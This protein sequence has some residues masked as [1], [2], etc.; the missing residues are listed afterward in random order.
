MK[1]WSQLLTIIISALL[2]LTTFTFAE[3]GL[4]PITG[5][6]LND[7]INF[8]LNGVSTVPVGDDGTPVLPISYKGTTYIPLRALGYL[9]GL[10][11]DY[12]G[13]TKT[14]L[15]TSTTTKV[16][17]TAVPTAK[18]NKLIAIAGALINEQLKF[19]LDS[20]AATPK[21]DDGVP[22]LPISYNG[23]TYLPVRAV[24][25]LLGLSITYKSTSR[26]VQIVNSKKYTD[27]Q[28]NQV[29]II[30][31]VKAFADKAVTLIVGNPAPADSKFKNPAEA[32]GEPNYSGFTNN[33]ATMSGI[34]SLGGGGSVI[35][36]FTQVYIVD[37]PGADIHVFEVG[38]AVESMAIEVSQDNIVWIKIGNISGGTASVDLA[39]KVSATD[40][41]S[42]VKLTDL[43]SS[44]SGEWPGADVDAVAG[45]NTISK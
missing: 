38:P 36:E 42:F 5:A 41:F 39:G 25:N 20:K 16:A 7:Q 19:S 13:P 3:G 32:L 24:A 8:S 44:A 28:G 30:S 4:T 14:A 27:G 9:L 26:T 31:G 29:K 2:V 35:L 37:G 21:G 22:V 18:S 10:G 34:L 43:R 6:V 45:I 15:L 17:P 11:V 40:R 1:K 12:D 23:T 33:S